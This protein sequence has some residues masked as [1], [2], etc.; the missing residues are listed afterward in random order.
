MTL[1]AVCTLS[2]TIS[3]AVSVLNTLVKLASETNEF[4]C[5]VNEFGCDGNVLGC[6]GNEFGCVGNEFGC[7]GND[8]PLVWVVHAGAALVGAGCGA[9]RIRV[10]FEITGSNPSS[11]MM[12]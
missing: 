2:T 3:P 11:C 8:S 5:D 9:A 4:G 12:F 6:V 7:D 10:L 1:K